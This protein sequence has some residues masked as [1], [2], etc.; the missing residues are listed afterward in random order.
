MRLDNRNKFLLGGFLLM[1]FLGHHLAFKKTMT[2][3]EEYVANA[4][5]QQLARHVPQE[6]SMLA[7]KEKY[8]DAQFKALNLGASSLQN[9]LLKFLN[10]VST[11][12]NV[13]VIEF[14]L[15]HGFR[16]KDALVK[17]H[18]FNLEG[19]FTDILKVVH[20]LEKQGSFGTI[21][22]AAFEKKE[23]HRNGKSSLQAL[24]FLEHV[25]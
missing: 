13:K 7:Q 25:E 22:H 8:L 19:G 10:G 20:A 5:K 4:E 18:I 14:R 21:S 17:T 9:D 16:E 12:N 23:D 2:L 1:L 15:P 3:K 24:I 11:A 6:L